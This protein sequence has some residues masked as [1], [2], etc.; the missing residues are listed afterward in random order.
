[1]RNQWKIDGK[2]TG[3]QSHPI[4]FPDMVQGLVA[5]KST[6]VKGRIFISIAE[7]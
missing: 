6:F 3:K 2:P 5:P 4:R 7:S 1:M